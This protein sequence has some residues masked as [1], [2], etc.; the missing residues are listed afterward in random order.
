MSIFDC[1]K[2]VKTINNNGVIIRYT[3]EFYPFNNFTSYILRCPHYLHSA[4]RARYSSIYGVDVYDKN[5]I[6]LT[7]EDGIIE[8]YN[9][10]KKGESFYGAYHSGQNVTQIN[11]GAD[12]NFNIVFIKGNFDDYDRFMVNHDAKRVSAIHGYPGAGKEY[13][14]ANNYEFIDVW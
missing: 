5:R 12:Y 9:E 4:L 1:K 11:Y 14:K 3:K 6:S 2:E 7:N 8:V 13:A 10:I